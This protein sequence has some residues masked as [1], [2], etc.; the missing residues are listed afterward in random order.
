LQLLRGWWKLVYCGSIHRLVALDAESVGWICI[1]GIHKCSNLGFGSIFLIVW[2]HVSPCC[3]M[4]AWSCA[5]G[6]PFYWFRWL[7]VMFQS[8][9][10]LFLLVL[11]LWVPIWLVI[12][13]CLGFLFGLFK[14][15]AGFYCMTYLKA[16]SILEGDPFLFQKYFNFS[17]S[18]RYWHDHWC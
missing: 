4:R 5:D 2:F 10:C 1:C 16:S 11:S 17:C 7:C 9:V 13:S 15:W 18:S 3:C 8:V 12:V 14:V 6:G